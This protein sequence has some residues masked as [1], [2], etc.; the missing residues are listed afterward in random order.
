MVEVKVPYVFCAFHLILN[1][2]LDSFGHHALECAIDG[3]RVE[4]YTPLSL[5]HDKG[6]SCKHCLVN[7]LPCSVCPLLQQKEHLTR[8]NGRSAIFSAGRLQVFGRWLH[9]LSMTCLS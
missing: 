1:C 9:V 7:V 6:C 2:T 3:P 4:N 8:R 5:K